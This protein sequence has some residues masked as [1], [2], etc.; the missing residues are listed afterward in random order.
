MKLLQSAIILAISSLIFSQ[1]QAQDRV[2][3]GT[4]TPQQALDVVGDV[5]ITTDGAYRIDN[6]KVLHGDQYGNLH[7]GKNAGQDNTPINGLSNDGQNNTFVG[8]EAGR[9]NSTGFRNV[10]MGYRA[11][12]NDEDG[13]QNT[14]IG[15][16]AGFNGN[17]GHNTVSIGSSSGYNNGGVSN[18]FIGSNS[19]YANMF[20]RENVFVGASAGVNNEAGSYNI[21]LGSEAGNNFT[22]GQ[23]NVFI[24]RFAGTSTT[25]GLEYATAIGSGAKVECSDCLV[26]G[27]AVNSEQSVNVGIGTKS[28][29]TKLHV[30]G[31]AG[32]DVILKLRGAASTD[33][34][35]IQLF[36]EDDN[37]F[38]WRHV[39]LDN[40]LQLWQRSSTGSDYQ[41]MAFLDDGKVGIGTDAPSR[42]FEVSGSGTQ[43]LRMTSTSA[44]VSGIEMV[45]L[46]GRSYR[47]HG[48]GSW[49]VFGTSTDEFATAENSVVM[50]E[51]TYSF[52]PWADGGFS[53]GNSGYRWEEIWAENDVIQTSDARLKKNVAPI[54]YGLSEV[55]AMRPVTYEW[56]KP[57]KI[58]GAKI[59]FLAQEMQTII[60][61]AVV[62]R[63]TNTQQHPD[64]K[65]DGLPDA[66]GMKYSDLIPVLVKAIQEQQEVINNVQSENDQ[67]KAQNAAF[68][69]ELQAIKQHLGME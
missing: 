52:E 65:T 9:D 51:Q 57:T 54:Q 42:L 4:D 43:Y 31:F 34:A 15:Y 35:A 6:D 67:L 28:P 22:S 2:G 64:R 5:N 66:Y 48:T 33:D 25:T 19:G 44:S 62:H 69:K 14:I 17:G 36:E 40:E 7:V 12:R 39:G 1:L 26:L 18:V 3:I 24:G 38:E 30:Q 49:L 10:M 68:E 32:D 8:H 37:G 20:G 16:F 27:R 63:T 50:N 13:Q 29:E 23:N 58:K 56:I 11:G 47:I 55:L 61:E 53:L 45:R 60:P 46:G 41:R 59:G 21:F